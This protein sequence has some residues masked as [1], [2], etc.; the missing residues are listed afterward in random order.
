MLE[1][2]GN[3]LDLE[4]TTP[5]VSSNHETKSMTHVRDLQPHEVLGLGIESL[6]ILFYFLVS[7]WSVLRE[8]GKISFALQLGLILHRISCYVRPDRGHTSS[9][10]RVFLQ[11]TPS[12]CRAVV[13]VVG[14]STSKKMNNFSGHFLEGGALKQRHMMTNICL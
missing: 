4:Q 10:G 1:F 14:I 9:P 8:Q 2:S 11:D 5:K 6:G 3:T 7:L 13:C 12:A